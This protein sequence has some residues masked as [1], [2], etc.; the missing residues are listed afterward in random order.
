MEFF[1]Q[2]MENSGKDHPQNCAC[3][4]SHVLHHH[5]FGDFL[6]CFG[7]VL[8]IFGGVF[9]RAFLLTQHSY[10]S[11]KLSGNKLNRGVEHTQCYI[12][13]FH[14]CKNVRLRIETVE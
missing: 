8:R 2:V 12:S 6:E 13:V 4:Y 3:S 9:V 10:F 7:T 14:N 1:G 5:R 11:T